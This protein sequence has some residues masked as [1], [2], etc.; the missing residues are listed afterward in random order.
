[1]KPRLN[2]L[3]YVLR[4]Q[5]ETAAQTRQFQLLRID[6]HQTKIGDVTPA[7]PYYL[8]RECPCQFSEIQL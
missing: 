4:R 3:T 7:T 6:P 5:V 1:M 8:N 2:D